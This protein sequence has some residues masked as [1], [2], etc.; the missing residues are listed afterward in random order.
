MGKPGNTHQIGK[1]LGLG[2]NDHLDNKLRAKLRDAETPQLTAS[3]LFRR[4]PQRLR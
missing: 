1:T 2:I 3:D 4:N